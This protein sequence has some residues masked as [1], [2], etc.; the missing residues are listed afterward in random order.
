[1]S[2]LALLGGNKVRPE[3]FPGYKVIGA[4]EKAAVD[5]VIEAGHDPR[6]FATD[7]LQRLRDLLVL[8]AVPVSGTE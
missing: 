2:K 8:S 5:R 6:R 3:L 1:M 7:L 4:E